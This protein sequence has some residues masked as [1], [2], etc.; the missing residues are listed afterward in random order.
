MADPA[1]TELVQRIRKHFTQGTLTRDGPDAAPIG[2]TRYRFRTTGELRLASSAWAAV[3][4][5]TPQARAGRD[6]RLK[7]KGG[8]LAPAP[9]SLVPKWFDKRHIPGAGRHRRCMRRSAVIARAL[10]GAYRSTAFGLHAAR[11]ARQVEAC[12]KEDI[13]P[14]AAAGLAGSTRRSWMRC[15]AT[16]CE[17]SDAWLAQHAG[18]DARLSPGLSDEE[19]RQPAR[20]W[21]A[22]PSG[23]RSARRQD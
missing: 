11:I 1:F 14:L 6:R 2:R 5:A 15:C 10:S 3:V 23:I 22:S 16:G 9:S 21:N 17:L 12:A 18:V 8:Q 19:I 20:G 7:A 13:P 4:N